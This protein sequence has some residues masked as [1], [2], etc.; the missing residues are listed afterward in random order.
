MKQ[1]G[2]VFSSF[3]FWAVGT[4]ISAWGSSGQRAQHYIAF[5]PTPIPTGHTDPGIHCEMHPGQLLL[6]FFSLKTIRSKISSLSSR[7]T[8]QIKTESV[9]VNDFYVGG[10][11]SC[12]PLNG[13]FLNLFF[14]TTGLFRF[15]FV[16]IRRI[17][18]L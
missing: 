3:V 5:L 2:F 17:Q 16:P 4:V 10:R 18:Y 11:G 6:T 9:H 13:T 8:N 14:S 12:P 1:N 7:I 15:E